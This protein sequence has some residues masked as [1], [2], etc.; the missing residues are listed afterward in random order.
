MEFVQ[1]IPSEAYS[2]TES[3]STLEQRLYIAID[4]PEYREAHSEEIQ[5]SMKNYKPKNEASDLSV[6]YY[7]FAIAKLDSEK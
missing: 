6:A 5:E 3:V 7:S 4:N 1:Q 2:E